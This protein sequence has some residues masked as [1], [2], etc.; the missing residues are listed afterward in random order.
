MD[1]ILA[2]AH[3]W[4]LESY[5]QGPYGDLVIRL[6]E[7]I[8]GNAR[9]LVHVGEQTLGP[10]YPVTVEPHSR[11]VAIR[12]Q[13]L[14]C[15]LTFTE[16]FDADDPEME[17]ASGTFLRQ[18]SASSFR[19]FTG[20]TTTAIDEFRGAFSEW[21]VWTED[22]IFQVLSGRPPEVLLESRSP[23]F[24]IGRGGTWSAS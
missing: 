13:D 1:S 24:S 8:K 11:C 15:L 5:Q 3:T 19:N 4:F 17:V 16:G 14:H 21:L 20:K 23:D 6:V 9:Q 18:V 12:F 10:Y 22:Q 7:G 2:S